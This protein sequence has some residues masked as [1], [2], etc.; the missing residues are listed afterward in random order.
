MLAGYRLD[1]TPHVVEAGRIRL[2]VDLEL[3]GK[4]AR[5]VVVV[6]DKQLLVLPTEI[7][8]DERRFVLLVRPTIVHGHDDL[9]AIMAS[10]K[11][12]TSAR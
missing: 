3:R 11:A 4:N 6:D 1:V 12:T 2:D 7:M 9:E 8:L 5:T 10:K